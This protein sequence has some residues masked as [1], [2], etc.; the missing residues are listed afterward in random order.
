MELP[1]GRATEALEE[2][3]VE[4]IS[5]RLLIVLMPNFFPRATYIRTK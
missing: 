4:T 5:D 1:N 2:Y 3:E